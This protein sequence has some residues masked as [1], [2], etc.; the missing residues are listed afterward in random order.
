MLEAPELDAG[1]QAASHQS[2]AEGQ[3]PLPQPVGHD[4]FDAVQD[5]AGLLGCECTLSIM[6]SFI[7]LRGHP[8]NYLVEGQFWS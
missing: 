4:S 6:K 5:T 1:L 8:L 2:R 7:C 3:N